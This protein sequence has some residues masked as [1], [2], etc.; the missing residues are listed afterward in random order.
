MKIQKTYRTVEVPCTRNVQQ[1]YK[2]KVPRTVKHKVPKQ[3]PYTD[4]EIK[5]ETVPVQTMRTETKYR[6]VIRHYKEPV[7]KQVT[8]YET[9][10]RRVPKIIYQ[11][12][13]EK[14]PRTVTKVVYEERT[15]TD[16]VPYTVRVPETKYVNKK[17][18]YPV[19]K[20][21]IE[22]VD[23]VEIKYKDEW[24]TKCEPVTKMVQKKIPVFRAVPKQPKPC[25]PDNQSGGDGYRENPAEDQG[26][27][28]GYAQAYGGQAS[29]GGPEL[30]AERH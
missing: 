13:K 1:K 20:T 29:Y 11:N 25:P 14:V 23:K 27:E 24:R 19:T 12:K 5:N 26:A 8:T 30:D 4:Y 16:Q 3:V 6:D 15:R 10:T 22:Y 18:R 28:T 21:K 2:V 7:T 17:K 9:V